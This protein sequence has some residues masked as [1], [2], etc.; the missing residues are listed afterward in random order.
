MTRFATKTVALAA[1]ALALSLGTQAQGATS[2]TSPSST[3]S[4]TGTAAPG[5]RA[6]SAPASASAPAAK[7]A[8]MARADRKFIEDAAMSGMAEVEMGKLAQQKASDAKVK[9]FAQ[10]MSFEAHTEPKAVPGELFR[11]MH[12]ADESR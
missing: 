2:T 12:S 9:D 1:A 6:G 7:R 8:D 5:A 11:T 10:R 3:T 4:T